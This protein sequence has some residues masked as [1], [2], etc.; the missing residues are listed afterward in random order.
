MASAQELL[1]W[2]DNW[3]DQKKIDSLR[4]ID[5]SVAVQEE[6]WRESFEKYDFCAFPGAENACFRPKP[7]TTRK[8]CDL[9]VGLTPID[10]RGDD[11]AKN[12]VLLS[13]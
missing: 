9:T 4:V 7:Q 12:F 3:R 10:P 1:S 8:I 2:M 13:I 6:P 11:G 5:R